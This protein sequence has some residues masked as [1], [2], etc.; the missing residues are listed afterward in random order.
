MKIFIG[1]DSREPVAYKV[2]S[3]SIKRHN[4]NKNVSIYPLKQKTLRELGIY[5]RPIDNLA[6]TEFSLTRF[7]IPFLSDYVGFSVFMDCDFLIQSDIQELFDTIDKS[8]AVSVV[9]HD[10]IPKNT[11]KMDGKIQHIY[12]RKNWSSLMIF[13]NAHPSNKKLTLELVNNESSQYLHRLSWLDDKE[14]GDIDHTWNYLVGWYNDLEKPK[15][16][17]YTDGG[18]WFNDYYNCDFSKEWLYEY[19]LAHKNG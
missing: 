13:N 10:F 5:N 12:P 16:I 11:T 14:I 1:W 2:C 8:K 7:L 17:H 3:F 18:P 19:Y 15:A 9:K 6:S 4:K